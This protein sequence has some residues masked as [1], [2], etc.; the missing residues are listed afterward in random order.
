MA[1]P[2]VPMTTAD[3]WGA[4]AT[5]LQAPSDAKIALGYTYGEKLPYP[6]ANWRDNNYTQGLVNLY[7]NGILAWDAG[8]VYV[9]G[10]YTTYAGYTYISLVVDNTT[11]PSGA[12]TSTAEWAYDMVG[13]A[14]NITDGTAGVNAG[15]LVMTDSNGKIATNLMGVGALVYVGGVDV[16]LAP[17]THSDAAQGSSGNDPIENGDFWTIIND[18][19]GTF[20]AGYGSLAGNE[21]YR[22]EAIVYD[23][24]DWHI[25]GS[26]VNDNYV[27]RDGSL[28]MTGFLTLESNDPTD[29]AHATHKKYVNDRD[30]EQASLDTTGTGSGITTFVN[31][32]EGPTTVGGDGN[33]TYTTKGYVDTGVSTAVSNLSTVYVPLDGTTAMTG[34]LEL[35]T[36]SSG[37]AIANQATTKDYVDTQFEVGGLGDVY[38]RVTGNAALP[39]T[40]ALILHTNTPSTDTE[41]TSKLYVTTSISTAVADYVE[42]DG[43]TTM[44]GELVLPVAAPSTDS[45][46]ANKKYVDDVAAPKLETT[47]YSTSTF[48]GTLKS[49]YDGATQT[50]YLTNDGTNP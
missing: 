37:T 23:G 39:M 34:D 18:P 12:A 31:L 49:R 35:P 22:G 43:S 48:S 27:L 21:G 41:A 19:S 17:P 6:Q 25:L 32:V 26:G 10:A 9:Q 50:L 45:V 11:T 2:K 46:A 13:T 15:K 24:A 38:V 44:T 47:D 3:I 30:A 1:T 14:A 33:S 29:N 28:P 36:Y 40:G 42:K 7:E 20:E 4:D 16:T 5:N 8:T